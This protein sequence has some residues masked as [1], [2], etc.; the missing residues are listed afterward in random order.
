MSAEVPRFWRTSDWR[1]VA[2]SALLS[3]AILAY[4]LIFSPPCRHWFAAPFAFL[5]MMGYGLVAWLVASEQLGQRLA[6]RP[7]GDRTSAPELGEA[8]D[9]SVVR[10]A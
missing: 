10:A 5:F 1:S 3:T 7:D 9:P 4:F 8:A 6:P 2:C